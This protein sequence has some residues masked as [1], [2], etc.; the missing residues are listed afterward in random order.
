MIYFPVSCNV[1]TPGHI[2]CLEFLCKKD[3]VIVGL[4]TAKALKGYKKEIVPFEDRKFI[5]EHIDIYD[6]AIVP[7]E[8][9]D[10][11]ENIIGYECDAIA[12]GDG[13]EKQ[14]LESI[15]K[16]GLKTI[17]IKLNGEKKKKYSSSKII[18]KIK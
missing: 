2:K 12:S 3:F 5:L 13:W 15:K 9:L 1:L 17:N 11:T 16:L 18:K 6:F 4:L 14:E 7:Q 8:S 10:P